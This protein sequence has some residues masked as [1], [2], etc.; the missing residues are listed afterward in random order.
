MGEET[1]LVIGSD[2][3]GSDGA[4]FTVSVVTPSGLMFSD[5]MESGP[6][7]WTVENGG[8]TGLA[9]GWDHREVL[10]GNCLFAC[11]TS[12]THFWYGGVRN[13]AGI[14]GFAY[15]P[16]TDAT[17]RPAE[18]IDL[19]GKTAATLYYKVQGQSTAP[20]IVEARAPGGQWSQVDFVTGNL[21]W[22]GGVLF[23]TERSVDLSGFVGDD[24]EFRF[25]Y[26]VRAPS[27]DFIDVLFWSVFESQSFGG[28]GV[29]DIRLEATA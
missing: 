24:V 2:G 22:G 18:P 25:R 6:S 28:W 17:I 29:D 13:T 4:V 23:A 7:K 16:G 19:A 21:V 20:M 1:V 12:G 10:F 15:A 27:V 11:P 3:S 5:D 9:A 8:T 14:A 26:T